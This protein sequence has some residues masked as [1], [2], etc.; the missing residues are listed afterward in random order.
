MILR[1]PLYAVVT[2][3]MF[4]C[5]AFG[6]AF[7]NKTQTL[8][9]SVLENKNSMDAKAVDLD[10][11]GDLDLIVGVEFYKNVILINDGKGN[12]TD[13]SNRLPDIQPKT[14]EKPYPYY[15]YH[16]T[17]DIALEDF[18]KDGDLDLI[19]VTEDDEVNEYYRNDGNGYFTD[20][21]D[22]FPAKGISNGVLAGDFDKDG[23]TDLI[24][25]NRGQNTYLRND[26]GV[27][28]D[29]TGKRLP[30][31]DNIT[32]DMQA[33]DFDRDGDI[34]II[35]ANE[36]EN[37]ILINDGKGRFKNAVQNHI[38]KVFLDEETREATF[39]DIDNDGDTDLYF[40]NVYMFRK[41]TPTQRL[42]INDGKNNFRDETKARLGFTDQHSVIDAD[43][44][45]FDAD[46]D[47]D[48]LLLGHQGPL[49]FQNNGK[50]YFKSST[51]GTIG[52]ITAS[53]V[54]AEIADFNNDG[55]LD[56]YIA[57]FRGSDVLLLQK[58][59]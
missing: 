43:F 3:F 22:T 58:N 32:Q 15:P 11:D 33:L 38:D 31:E 16:D 10:N 57:V 17:E 51:S 27:F 23:W 36:K 21:T 4:T 47:D 50:G 44:A 48:L 46:G 54:D 52:N 12:F 20:I 26:K 59:Q 40:A 55:K 19:F 25:G 41:K 14:K 24:I 18:D 6:Q 9:K 49:L 34:D 7:I 1:H 2:C 39:A 13:E 5:H 30:K 37:S 45:D 35:V 42:L 8:P 28:K 29:E 53:G 56:I